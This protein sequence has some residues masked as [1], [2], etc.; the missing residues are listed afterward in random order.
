M[1][2]GLSQLSPYISQPSALAADGAAA[3]KKYDYVVVGGGKHPL[4]TVPLEYL[5]HSHAYIVKE[6]PDVLW[7]L[8]SP[9][10]VMSLSCLLK[11]DQGEHQLVNHPLRLGVY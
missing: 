1:G 4:S 5:F 6:P 11:Q 10:T 8:G 3:C 9:K 2:A 7:H